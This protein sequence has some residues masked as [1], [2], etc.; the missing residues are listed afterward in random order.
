MNKKLLLTILFASIFFLSAC[1]TDKSSYSQQLLG[2]GEADIHSSADEISSVNKQSQSIKN[3]KDSQPQGNTSQTTLTNQSTKISVI[4]NFIKLGAG[5]ISECQYQGEMYFSVDINNFSLP[6]MVYD[7]RGKQIL[8]C[9]F[10]KEKRYQL[11]PMCEKLEKCKLIYVSDVNI[12][13]Y[14]PVN[15]Y[16][17]DIQNAK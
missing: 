17:I 11:N 5:M 14:N 8:T 7:K 10:D 16:E 2:S 13:G 15:K 1:S 3:I 4:T 6:N 12:R 9:D